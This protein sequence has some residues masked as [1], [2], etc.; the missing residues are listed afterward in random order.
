[1][2]SWRVAWSQVR[3][4]ALVALMGGGIGRAVLAQA[5]PYGIDRRP[6]PRGTVLDTLLPSAVGPFRRAAFAPHTAVPVTEELLV[7]Y[8]AGADTVALSFRIPG[9][10]E[11]AQA[12]VRAGR[13]RAK[14]RKVDIARADYVASGDPSYF[15]SERIMA[16][17]RG[18]YYF[19]ADAASP[20]ALDRFM[21]AFPY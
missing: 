8:G 5:V 7:R 18:G 13:D 6:Q 16:W 4:V 20:G 9:R 10:P 17:S 2:G 19:F 15:Q 1:M 3:A 11:D 21:R 14:S 12:A